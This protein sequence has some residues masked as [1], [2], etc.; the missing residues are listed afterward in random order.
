MN[1][2]NN[3]S[4]IFGAALLVLL[5]YLGL[6]F[7]NTQNER[8]R[9]KSE[10][11]KGKDKK[12][13]ED[14]EKFIEELDKDI[15]A[16]KK[17]K[18]KAMKVRNLQQYIS[19]ILIVLIIST[20]RPAFAEPCD[21]ASPLCLEYTSKLEEQNDALKQLNQILKSQRDAAYD[22][23]AECLSSQ[24]LIPGWGYAVLGLLTGFVL[25]ATLK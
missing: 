14:L 19:P 24:P 12:A 16:L 2:I 3:L 17:K 25:H 4:G 20:T 5:A 7:R 9:L 23:E 6:R 1:L 21:G 8:N 18:R 22:R 10:I 11:Q 13:T 15:E